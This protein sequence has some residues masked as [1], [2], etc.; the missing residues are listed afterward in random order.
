MISEFYEKLAKLAVNYAVG[1]KKGQ[2]VAVIGPAIAKE[3][4]QAVYVEVLK[5]GGHPLLIL[6]SKGH[7][8]YFSSMLLKNSYYILTELKKVYMKNL[9]ASSIFLEIITGKNFR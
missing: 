9:I 8:N 4:F 7:K 6:K 2:R 1:V 3:L 5:A